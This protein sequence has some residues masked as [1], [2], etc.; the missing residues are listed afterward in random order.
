MFLHF[1]GKQ[2]SL[3]DKFEYVMH[4]L[5]YKMTEEKSKAGAKVYAFLTCS[6]TCLLFGNGLYQFSKFNSLASDL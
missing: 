6:K 4:G 2:K 5:L 3:A 1:Q